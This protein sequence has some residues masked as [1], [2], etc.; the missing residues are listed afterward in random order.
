MAPKPQFYAIIAIVWLFCASATRGHSDW[1]GMCLHIL[2]GIGSNVF[3][4]KMHELLHPGHKDAIAA[5]DRHQEMGDRVAT[6][7]LR[8]QHKHKVRALPERM[9][10]EQTSRPL[11]IKW[12]FQLLDSTSPVLRE[13]IVDRLMPAAAA[14]LRRAVRVWV[15][16]HRAPK[17]ASLLPFIGDH[18]T[19]L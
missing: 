11:E 16:R 17:S 2:T 15:L 6:R 19:R 7:Q 1:C 10:Q 18:F 8:E 4:Y 14:V 13:Y 9:M 3:R 12:D 5:R